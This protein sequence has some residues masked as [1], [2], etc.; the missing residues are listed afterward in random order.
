[1]PVDVFSPNTNAKI[2][3]MIMP[4]PFIPDFDKPN[5]NAAKQKAT[6]CNTVR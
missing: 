4:M 6:H 3:T 5:K 1:M 2:T